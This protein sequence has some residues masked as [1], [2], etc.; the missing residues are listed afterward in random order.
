MF[1]R[2]VVAGN[3]SPAGV[4]EIPCQLQPAC[5]PGENCKRIAVDANAA[6][7]S[8]GETGN[9]VG[10]QSPLHSAD[11]VVKRMRCKCHPR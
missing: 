9:I 7:I 5:L 8:P 2:R 11:V 10:T 4:K 6:C 3:H 1:D